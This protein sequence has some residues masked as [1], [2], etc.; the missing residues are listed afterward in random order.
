MLPEVLLLVIVW[1]S[2]IG[3]ASMRCSVPGPLGHR[4]EDVH[5]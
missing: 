4:E 3:R 5:V 2:Q 1:L